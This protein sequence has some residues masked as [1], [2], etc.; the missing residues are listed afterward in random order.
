MVREKVWASTS[1]RKMFR[2][3]RWVARGQIKEKRSYASTDTGLKSGWL[4]DA[5]VVSHPKSGRTWLRFMLGKY[6]ADLRGEVRS[7]A[8]YTSS[9]FRDAREYPRIAF[10]HDHSSCHQEFRFAADE[11]PADKSFYSDSKVLLLTRDPRDVLVSYYMHCTQRDPI[12]EGPLGEFVRDSM[13]GIEKIVR[14][15]NLWVDGENAAR[16]FM[17]LRY[18]DLKLDAESAMSR[19]VSFLGL[20][21]DEDLIAKAV[22]YSRLDNMKKLERS[23]A[24]SGD[25]R[26]GAGSSGSQDGFKVR[27]GRVGGFRQAMSDDDTAYCSQYMSAHLDPRYGY[28][29]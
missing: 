18:E 22:D 6:I 3:L 7:P 14:F 21:V 25:E 12:Y 17:L 9:V 28:G 19:T 8:E 5:F 16:A 1:M 11:L 4:S 29:A 15:M 13:F 26:F 23:G 10:V 2:L 27:Q 24:L 20:P